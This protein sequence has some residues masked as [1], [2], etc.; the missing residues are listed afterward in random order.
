MTD[1]SNL[2]KTDAESVTNVA[3]TE[4]TAESTNNAVV[5]KLRK[6][7]SEISETLTSFQNE[8]QKLNQ[9]MSALTQEMRL[10]NHQTNS[11]PKID[12]TVLTNIRKYFAQ[13]RGVK[14]KI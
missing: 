7:V 8:N 2:T 14:I 5:K 3:K 9:S 12:E 4:N 10:M 11:A 13:K 1:T 6:Q